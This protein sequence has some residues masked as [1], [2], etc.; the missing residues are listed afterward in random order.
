MG[1]AIYLRK[2]SKSG[3]FHGRNSHNYRIG[4]AATPATAKTFLFGNSHVWLYDLTYLV[5]STC[6]PK[7]RDSVNLPHV[8]CP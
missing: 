7:S 4:E 5:Y 2:I 3:N 8:S 6:W 1:V